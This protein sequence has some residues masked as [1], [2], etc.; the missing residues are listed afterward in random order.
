[1]GLAILVGGLLAVIV[2][3]VVG[4]R[5][6]N[7]AIERRRARFIAGPVAGIG[8]LPAPALP[9]DLPPFELLTTGKNRSPTN[10]NRGLVRG[11]DVVL[12]DY[13][14]RDTRMTEFNGLH[15]RD[16]CARTTIACARG[17]GLDLPPFAIEPDLSR[18]FKDV[19]ATIVPQVGDGAI[20]KIANALMTLAEGMATAQEGWRFSDRPDVRY[21]VRSGDQAAV[22]AAFTP[23]VLDFFRD[24]HGWIVEGRGS[25]VMVTFSWQFRAPALDMRQQNADTGRLPPEQIGALVKAA[26]DTIEVFR[27]SRS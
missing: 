4:A 19:E 16:H 9:E 17:A 22:R 18:V 11:S 3:I 12:F 1:M 7:G 5:W 27:G 6:A 21:V 23:A 14:F 13:W 26:A 24:H 8:L 25:W 20:G 2:L 15:Y 10:I